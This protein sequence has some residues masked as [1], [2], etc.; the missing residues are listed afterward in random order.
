[1]TALPAEADRSWR[2]HNL[3]HIR[4]KDGQDTL[5]KPLPWQRTYL[6]NLHTRNVLVK[7]R[8]MG[9]T[10]INCLHLLDMALSRPQTTVGVIAHR[11]D[12][13]GAKDILRN[14]ILYPL[15]HLDY[16][17][18]DWLPHIKGK[19][20]AERVELTNGSEISVSTS[21]RSGSLQALLITEF[22]PLE[23]TSP[24]RL[25][26]VKEG[27]LNT[28]GP[29]QFVAIESTAIGAVGEFHRLY[30]AAKDF[31]GE[32]Y[33]PLDYRPFFFGWQNMPEYALS[34]DGSPAYGATLSAYFDEVAEA[35]V[36]LTPGQKNFYAAKFR[37]MGQDAMWREFPTFDTEAFNATLKG[38]VYA[39]SFVWL[40][41]ERRLTTLPFRRE[42]PV[43]T[44]WD[45]GRSDATAIW[46]FQQV[47][48]YIHL[49]DYVEDSHQT[50][51]HYVD[52][53]EQR[54]RDKS[55]IYATHYLPHDADTKTLTSVAGSM[56]EI[57]MRYGHRILVIPQERKLVQIEQTRKLLQRCRFD[58]AACEQGL[59]A[60]QSY[61]YKWDGLRQ[62]Y[63]NEPVHNWASHGADAMAILAAAVQQPTEGPPPI[64]TSLRVPTREESRT[65][66]EGAAWRV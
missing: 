27:A 14:K 8:Q 55:Y 17:T 51:V 5:F 52:V 49:I 4:G 13:G 12:M 34:T 22:G 7:A 15:L 31:P 40:R 43:S 38:A 65:E 47:G 39:K 1:M 50:A 53:L 62:V 23:K 3:Y 58:A 66:Q 37:E 44:A 25:I 26:E 54:R 41:A 32:T 56:A 2:L 33:G 20:S 24:E 59:N 19:P 21:H 10:T 61:A 45:L 28:L 63:S 35:G 18:H 11:L 9:S 30:Q 16:E 57:L 42:Y 64:D 29:D 36:T 48:D 6:D 60:L 46:F